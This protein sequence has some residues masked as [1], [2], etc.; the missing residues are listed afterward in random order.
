ML[1][2]EVLSFSTL[3]FRYV[4]S[5]KFTH[6]GKKSVTFIFVNET[7]NMESNDTCFRCYF[8]VVGFEVKCDRC[9]LTMRQIPGA[10]Y[11]YSDHEGVAA[12]LT[13]R[14]R[15]NGMSPLSVI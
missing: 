12:E 14:E 10:D 8:G 11:P 2:I 6:L 1:R 3:F 15:E 13:V 7:F 4:W 5:K 9:W